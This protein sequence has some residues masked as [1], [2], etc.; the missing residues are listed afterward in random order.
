MYIIQQALRVD[1]TFAL[2]AII[3][4]TKI[5]IQFLVN[6]VGMLLLKD[7][8]SVH[9]VQLGQCVLTQHKVL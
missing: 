5:R 2:S 4:Q 6:Q 9:N 8:Q 3:V 1:A 7:K